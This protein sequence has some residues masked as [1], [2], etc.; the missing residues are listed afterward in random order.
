MKATFLK[1]EV[2]QPTGN[3]SLNHG[4]KVEGE[5][6]TGGMDGRL[7]KL[8]PP[9]PTEFVLVSAI[10]AAFDTGMPETFIFP[11][12]E[13]GKVTSWGELEGSFQGGQD[14]EKALRGLGVTEFA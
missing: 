13:D 3:N 2:L 1:V 7:Y 6:P 10:Q 11:A 5:D 9:V 4:I 14:H 8:D 12:D